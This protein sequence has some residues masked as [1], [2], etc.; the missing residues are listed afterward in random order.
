MKKTLLLF[1]FFVITSCYQE[2][3]IAIE[4]EFT[5]SYVDQDE[6]IPVII[7]IDNNK[8]ES[9]FSMISQFKKV[10]LHKNACKIL[11]NLRHFFEMLI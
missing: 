11:T 2:T 6:S 7:K 3:A 4:G 1:L 8:I 5:T 10:F 9:I